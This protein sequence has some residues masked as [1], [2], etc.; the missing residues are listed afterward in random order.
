[1][2][3]LLAVREVFQRDVTAGLAVG[4]DTASVGWAKAPLR[5][6]PTSYLVWKEA[7]GTLR[8]AHPTGYN[9]RMDR[10]CRP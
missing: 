5:A 9:F 1:M 7:V 10:H 4:G 8:F 3:G 6:V 2:A